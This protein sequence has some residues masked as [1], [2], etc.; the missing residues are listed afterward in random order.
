MNEKQQKRPD[1]NSVLESLVSFDAYDFKNSLF[2]ADRYFVFGKALIEALKEVKNEV[3][4][5]H[6]KQ[7][8]WPLLFQFPEPMLMNHRTFGLMAHHGF[9]F[10][11]M[12]EQKQFH[13][14]LILRMGLTTSAPYW[15]H[16]SLVLDVG[17]ASSVEDMVKANSEIEDRQ[18]VKE[19]GVIVG[20]RHWSTLILYA[21]SGQPDVRHLRGAR[22][23]SSRN[24]Q[25]KRYGWYLERDATLVGFDFKKPRVF[26]KEKTLVRM[27]PRWQPYKPEGPGTNWKLKLI[28]IE[29]HERRFKQG[30]LADEPAGE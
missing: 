6:L 3:S 26:S 25:Q 19:D 21:L 24:K 23:R 29:P 2:S 28:W 27:H 8:E 15:S 1:L 11:Y 18:W 12:P 20:I 16:S 30:P 10:A 9:V 14:M 13:F 22:D 17:T 5:D 4:I 7:T